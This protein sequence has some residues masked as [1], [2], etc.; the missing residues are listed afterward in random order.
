MSKSPE[1]RKCLGV[2]APVSAAEAQGSDCT[3]AWGRLQRT[4]R[5]LCQMVRGSR[6]LPLSFAI[7]R[8]RPLDSITPGPPAPPGHFIRQSPIS[9]CFHMSALPRPLL[10][11]C[12][13]QLASPA[14]RPWTASPRVWSA[15]LSQG[16]RTHGPPLQQEH[17]TQGGGPDGNISLSSLSGPHC[18]RTTWVDL[19]SAGCRECYHSQGTPS[20]VL[21]AYSGLSPRGLQAPWGQEASL[22][23]RLRYHQGLPVPREVSG[24]IETK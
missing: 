19:G 23:L 17:N 10:C 3:G 22:R 12:S 18:L 1:M 5:T 9:K 4:Q 15:Q 2:K 7:C 16:H 24:F 11:A 6:P 14:S 20:P 8:M 21:D 13:T